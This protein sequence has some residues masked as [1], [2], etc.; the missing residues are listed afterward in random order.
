MKMCVERMILSNLRGVASAILFVLVLAGGGPAKGDVVADARTRQELQT[1]SNH[2]WAKVQSGQPTNGAATFE[3]TDARF[4]SPLVSPVRG[5]VRWLQR[6]TPAVRFEA[7]NAVDGKTGG[8]S[9]NEIRDL[10]RCGWMAS[11]LSIDPD[12]AWT[13][14]LVAYESGS[15]EALEFNGTVVQSKNLFPV[16][17][18]LDPG[19][20]PAH[21]PVTALEAAYLN[22]LVPH[23][24]AISAGID[25]G[26]QR[27]RDGLLGRMPYWDEFALSMHDHVLRSVPGLPTKVSQI[28]AAFGNGVFALTMTCVQ[29]GQAY[30]LFDPLTGQMAGPFHVA[31]PLNGR[32]LLAAHPTHYAANDTVEYVGEN[33]AVMMFVRPIGGPNPFPAPANGVSV[34]CYGCILCITAVTASCA[35][36]CGDQPWW[37][38]PG[39]GFGMCM[40]KCSLAALG[41][42]L[43]LI[44]VIRGRQPFDPAQITMTVCD[45][46]CIGCAG[47]VV[48]HLR[49]W[50]MLP[51]RGIL[52][53]PAQWMGGVSACP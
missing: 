49:R 11:D 35:V 19:N 52:Q 45:G 27:M 44:E 21:P 39:E 31:E 10:M 26:V 14:I 30:A 47:E 3:F 7:D 13:H 20:G 17:V 2:Y 32:A 38:T 12:R 46:L 5:A 33:G 16:P 34:S 15:P 37:D 25:K 23:A 8:V 50:L 22:S 9:W 41:M 36:L 6:L 29:V 48:E 18:E 53:P 24:A 51:T 40:A 28:E 1:W 43:D 4:N 42:P